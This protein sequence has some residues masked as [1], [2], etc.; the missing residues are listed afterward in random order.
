MS[1]IKKRLFALLMTMVMALSLSV[2]AFAAEP[3]DVTQEPT[4]TTSKE[5]S[6]LQSLGPVIAMGSTTITGGYGS[7]DVYLSQGN[8]WA[9]LVGQIDIMDGN[10]SVSVSVITP[11]GDSI[12][13]GNIVGAGSR[14][15]P[16]ELAYA[17]AGTYRFAFYSACPSPYHVAAFIY[18]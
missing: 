11:D 13:L 3:V 2:S 7:M 1:I 10:Y 5:V 14:T 8:F 9:D 12:N 4:A 17:K 6:T 15:N 18:D 16:C